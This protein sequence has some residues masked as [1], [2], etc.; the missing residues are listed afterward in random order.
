MVSEHRRSSY[1]A[2]VIGESSHGVSVAPPIPPQVPVPQRNDVAEDMENPLYLSVNENPNAVLVTPLLSGSSNYASWS[3]SMRVALEVKNKWGLVDGSVP[4]PERT[5]AQYRSW[6]RCNLITSSWILRSVHTTIAQSVMYMDEAKEI[7]DDLKRRFSQRDANRISFL[8]SEISGLKQGGLSVNDYYTKCRTLWEEMNALR[9]LPIC[10][11]IPR[12]SCD[13]VDQIRKDREIDQVIRFLQGLDEE[14]NSLKSGVLMLDPLPEMHKVLVMSEKFERQLNL[15][16]LNS[17]GRDMTQANV[18]Q[19]D[20][21]SS[22]ETTA[23]AFNFSNGKK[24]ANSG[25]TKAKCSFCGMNGHTIKKCYKKHGYPPGWVQGY[26]S[27][28]KQYAA[29]AVA[30]QT[31][32]T[33]TPQQVQGLISLLDRMGQNQQSTN[34]AVSLV[35][36]FNKTNNTGDE[37][38]Y[39]RTKINSAYLTF[40]TWIVD[41][42]ATDHIICSLDLFDEFYTVNGAMVNLPNGDCVAVRHMGNIKLNDS[43]W[44]KDALHIPSFRFNIISVKRLLKNSSYSLMF[45]HDQ[46]LLVDHGRMIGFAREDKGLYLLNNPPVTSVESHICIPASIHCNNVEL[47]H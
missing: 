44:L 35:P 25:G 43:L 2:A 31:D 27:K 21:G 12:C 29:N 33:F 38:K 46:C 40:S 37:G 6:R 41:S 28:G 45:T 10:K 30:T 36:R 5:H 18:V 17:L 22:D 39:S 23:A 26:K 42:G 7:W 24:F 13:L 34:A 9:P 15:T 14:Y 47:W 11:C 20:Q 3:I 16:N 4:A 8:Q 1:A 19:I 32:Q